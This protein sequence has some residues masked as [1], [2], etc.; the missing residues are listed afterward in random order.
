MPK[1]KARFIEPML[2]LRVEKLPQGADWSYEIK[3]DGYRALAIKSGGKVQLRSRNDN[4]F[5]E[6]YSSVANALRS[7]PNET[8]LDGEVAALDEEG[9]PSFNLL[10]NYGSADAPLV[11][12]VFDLL[13]LNGQNVMAKPLSERRGLLESG[14]LPTLAEPIR[15]S[16]E[17]KASLPDLVASVKSAGL[18][19]LVAKRRNS[20]YEPGH[21]S[22]AWQKMRINRGQEFVIGGYTPS[23]RN[24]DALIF[25]YYNNGKLQYVARTRN[26]FTPSSR[27]QLFKKLRPLEIKQCPFTN[28]PEA[29]S[30]RWGAGLTAT[31]MK[32]CRWLK[33]VV[34]GQFEFTE[35][36]PDNHLRH[37]RFI[38]LRDDKKP[39]EVVRER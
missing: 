31:K 20:R 2:L 7:I 37:S 35:W 21:R 25:G 32:D 1:T 16:P 9:R 6:R 5:T 8:V 36:T 27:E 10:Q 18:E 23:D 24:F 17:L 38:A 13:M 19:G 14:V 39:K 33:P 12:F 29:R 3:L 26:G 11:Y 30:G 28:L 4:D 34:V 22:G 15:Y